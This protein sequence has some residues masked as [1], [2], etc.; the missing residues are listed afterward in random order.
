MR[1]R[2]FCDVFM[3]ESYRLNCRLITSVS[4]VSTWETRG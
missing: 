1:E 2:L 4:Y 3:S